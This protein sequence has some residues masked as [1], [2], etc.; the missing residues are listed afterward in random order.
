[1]QYIAKRIKSVALLVVEML[2]SEIILG[3][4]ITFDRK[5]LETQFFFS[6]S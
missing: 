3:N 5:E 2:R 6:L 1:M 4:F